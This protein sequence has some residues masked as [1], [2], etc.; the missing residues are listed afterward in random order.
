VVAPDPARLRA[1]VRDAAGDVD[2]QPESDAAASVLDDLLEHSPVAA[3]FQAKAGQAERVVLVVPDATRRGPWQ[4]WSKTVMQWLHARTVQ[5]LQ[6]TVLVATGVHRPVIG[7]H[8]DLADGWIPLANGEGGFDSHRDVGRTAAGTPVRLHPRW[9]QADLR[10]VLADISYH[11]FAGFGGGRKLVF[12]GLG[13]PEGIMANH[14]RSLDETGLPHRY[15]KPGR[16]ESNP[17]H[18]DLVDAVTLCPPDL[19]LQAVEPGK[20]RPITLELGDWR[21][22]HEAGCDRFDAGHR[23]PFTRPPELLVADAGGDPRDATFLQ[24]H[25]S[26]QHASRF[27]PDGGRLLLL[28]GLEEGIGSETLGRLWMIDSEALRKRALTDYRLHTHTALSLRLACERLRIGIWSS[29]PCEGLAQAGLVALGSEEEALAWIESE[30]SPHDWGWLPRAEEYLPELVGNDEK[31]QNR[32]DAS[33]DQLKEA[34]E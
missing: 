20:G 34:N 5:A 30:G 28:A 25:K 32:T 7:D 21:S 17:V 12:P 18:E 23:L 2:P 16:L 11:Y 33:G 15:A 24:A 13:D 10:V 6:H 14:R 27:L 9:V 4:I 22:V 31:G 3:E 26:L 19:L 29:T 8:L 1:L